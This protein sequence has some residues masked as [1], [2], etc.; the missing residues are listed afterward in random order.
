MGSRLVNEV[1]QRAEKK[2]DLIRVRNK[3]LA[4]ECTFTPQLNHEKNLDILRGRE[5]EETSFLERQE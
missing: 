2:L 5:G 1:S 3:E 4:E